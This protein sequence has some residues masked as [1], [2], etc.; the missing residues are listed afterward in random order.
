M[1]LSIQS[2]AGVRRLRQ[3]L[4]ELT[5]QAGVPRSSSCGSPAPG[6]HPNSSLTVA[7]CAGAAG[8]PNAPTRL[9]RSWSSCSRTRC[10]AGCGGGRLSEAISAGTERNPSSLLRHSNRAAD[11]SGGSRSPRPSRVPAADLGCGAN[12]PSF[13]WRPAR[14]RS[15]P[16]RRCAAAQPCAVIFAQ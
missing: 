16:V 15:A 1:W 13:M 9:Q 3:V 10:K 4:E 8:I 12:V 6:R 5:E 7:A 11:R 14:R 2:S